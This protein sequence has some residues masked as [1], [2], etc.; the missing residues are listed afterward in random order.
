M[1]RWSIR[2]RFLLVLVCLLL[3]VFGAITLLIVRQNTHTLK[4]NLIGQSKS[5]AALA[6]QPI[7]DAFVLYRDSGT[8]NIQ[9][10]VQHFT[11]LDTDINQVE[12]ID[13]SG[14]V[15]FMAD[16]HNKIKV[17]SN[18]ASSL[19]SSNI[20]DRNHNLVGII[21]PYIESF[22]IHRYAVIYG[23]SY[24]SVNHNIQS[25]VDGILIL[26]A[27]IL[28]FSLVV[29]YFLINQLFLKPVAQLSQLALVISH[30][31]LNRPIRLARR[32]EIGDLALA[33]DTMAGSLK[34]DITKLKEVDKLKNEFMMITSH[35][36][37]TPLTIINSYLEQISTMNP[38]KELKGLLEP[39]GLN[40]MRLGGFAED[41]LTVSTLEAGQD[42]LHKRPTE[43]RPVLETVAK[44][45]TGLAKQKQLH[46]TSD[47][48]TRATVDLSRQHFRSAIWNLLDNAY[49]FTADGG[50]VN[51]SARDVDG[52]VEITVKDSG[53]GIR[54]SE[55]PKLFTKFHRG[56]DTMQYDY[57]G[58][59]IGLYIAKLIIEQH[60]G[61]ITV[62][63]REGKGSTFRVTLPT[64]PVPVKP[65]SDAARKDPGPAESQ[66]QQDGLDVEGDDNQG[67]GHKTEQDSVHA[68]DVGGTGMGGGDGVR[69][70]LLDEDS[71][72]GDQKPGGDEPE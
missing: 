55:L 23:I 44:E 24:E 49:K 43:L 10:Q 19:T 42:I 21:Q 5:F 18:Q 25:I 59:G 68:E 61:H 67:K 37:R 4:D 56:T 39:I 2:V 35:N 66:P 13:S 60:G 40:A 11:E 51:L 16:S 52:Q 69:D 34:A 12:I 31:D 58:T 50:L 45:F 7:G 9:R 6:T 32:D 22:G 20:Y 14:Q 28:L 30:G 57:E 3:A 72:Q 8:I 47:I 26:S 64:M 41:V 62:D 63:S 48:S 53:I 29:W 46:F 17:S 1:R 54:Q 65:A 71:H 36:L 38:P 70:D 33:V 15:Q 27:A